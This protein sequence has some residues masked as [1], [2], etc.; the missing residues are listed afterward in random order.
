MYKKLTPQQKEERKAEIYTM[1][2]LG[3]TYEEIGKKFDIS[4]ERVRQ[5]GI[6]IEDGNPILFCKKIEKGKFERVCPVCKRTFLAFFSS[7]KRFC[8]RVC[9]VTSHRKYSTPEEAKAKHYER[10]KYRYHNEKKFRQSR[11]KSSLKWF[12]SL[13][14]RPESKER[15]HKYM[16]EY[17]RS[18][19]KS[20]KMGTW[21]PRPTAKLD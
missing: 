11:R 20:I 16:L 17:Q 12:S 7:K 4:R 21:K 6:K 9:A 10:V 2:S 18:R 5:I 13:K 1:R 8:S 15:Y 3:S 14:S 19:N